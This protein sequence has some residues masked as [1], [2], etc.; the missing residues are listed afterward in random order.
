M[1]SKRKDIQSFLSVN[2]KYPHKKVTDY[3]FLFFILEDVLLLDVFY[4][5]VAAF[6]LVVD[7]IQDVD[8]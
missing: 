6:A 5:F 2:L 4:Q 3:D 8:S 1:L 7:I